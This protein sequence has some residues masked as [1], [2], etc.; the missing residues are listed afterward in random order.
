MQNV[1]P[2]LLDTEPIRQD[3]PILREVTYLNV[4]TYGL[5]PDPALMQFQ[6]MQADF[7]R[8]GQAAQG[9]FYRKSE[10]TRLQ[11]ATLIHATPEEIA[12][13][14]NATDGINLALAGLD[15]KPGDE[16]ITTTEE[17]EAIQHPLLYLQKVK[18]VRIRLVEVS[19]Q[20]EEMLAELEKA[21]TGKT[22]LLALSYV[23]CETGTR[24]PATKIS[25]WAA[26]HQV[27]FLL[28]GAQ[29][30]GALP[31]D[32]RELGCDFYA[33]NGHKWLS[34][35]KGTGFFYAQREKLSQLNIAHVGAGSLE[36]ADLATGV[37]EPFK[38]GQ[39][40]EFGTRA[41]PIYAGLGCS[42]DYLQAIGWERIYGH[43]AALSDYFKE[44][45]LERPYL[46]LLTPRAY[47]V[48]SGLTSFVIEDHKA[49]EVGRVL[50][51]K[52]HMYTRVIPHY[53]AMRIATTYFNNLQD[54]DRLI[55]GL[56]EIV[57]G[58]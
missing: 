13:T 31:V 8:G 53:N 22:R 2:Q 57:Q 51:E 5:M 37:A 50:H 40:F 47:E 25:Q 55:E 15:W 21:Y 46:R 12:F 27:L 11:V 42:L 33:S 7:E 38:T 35:P 45:I 14:R 6:A 28:D 9:Q 36:R 10:E 18:G 48:S 19:S 24:L 58:R 49:G 30:S 32:V 34:G 17:H 16:V 1:I 3:F 29:A 41:W 20:A 4:G 39:R 23:T 52:W 44:R 43:I 54:I 56:D 26:A